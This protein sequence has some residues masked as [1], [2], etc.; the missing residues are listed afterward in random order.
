M[1]CEPTA[2]IDVANVATLGAAELLS[3]VLAIRTPPSKKETVPVGAVVA[4]VVSDTVAV[5][6][7]DCPRLEGLGVGG[8]V[9]KLVVVLSTAALVPAAAKRKANKI[10]S[11]RAQK[12]PADRTDRDIVPLCVDSSERRRPGG[13]S[14]LCNCFRRSAGNFV[15]KGLLGQQKSDS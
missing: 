10:A 5:N 2:K 15:T 9:D 11:K 4:V 7:T 12:R 1:V 13:A 6:V 14:K 3:V 8:V